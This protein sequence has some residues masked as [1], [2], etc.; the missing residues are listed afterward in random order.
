MLRIQTDISTRGWTWF[1]YRQSF[2]NMRGAG[3]LFAGCGALFAGFGA[4]I[5]GC[6]ALIAGCEI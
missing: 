6:G 3:A 4:L 2:S 1:T 5:A